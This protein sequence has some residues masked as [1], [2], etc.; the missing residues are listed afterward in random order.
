MLNLQPQDT[1]HPSIGCQ[2]TVVTSKTSQSGGINR[3]IETGTA[4]AKKPC[5]YYRLKMILKTSLN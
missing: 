4:T 3:S 1:I 2:A 5:A